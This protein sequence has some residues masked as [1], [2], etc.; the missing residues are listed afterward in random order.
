MCYC[1]SQKWGADNTGRE[2]TVPSEST[3]A[4]SEDHEHIFYRLQNESVAGKVGQ[5]S[6][7]RLIQQNK[8]YGTCL[9]QTCRGR[10]EASWSPSWAC[11]VWALLPC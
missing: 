6:N 1:N 10:R 3:R 4:A 2:P 8:I 11:M 5:Q 7:I 9:T